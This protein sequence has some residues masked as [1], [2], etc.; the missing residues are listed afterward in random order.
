MKFLLVDGTVQSVHNAQCVE[1]ET[2]W[3]VKNSQI[4]ITLWE[5]RKLSGFLSTK[6][7]AMVEKSTHTQCVFHVIGKFFFVSF[8]SFFVGSLTYEWLGRKQCM[9]S[10]K[11]AFQSPTCMIIPSG[12]F[13]SLHEKGLMLQIQKKETQKHIWN[14]LYFQLSLPQKC[15]KNILLRNRNCIVS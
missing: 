14:H 3:V 2:L 10:R 5:I 12:I 1:R 11:S 7:V 9:S 8:C 4:C 6:Q 15:K 13:F